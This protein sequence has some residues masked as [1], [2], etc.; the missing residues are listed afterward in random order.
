MKKIKKKINLPKKILLKTLLEYDLKI[1]EIQAMN[2]LQC[3]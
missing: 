2:M 1:K 3:K